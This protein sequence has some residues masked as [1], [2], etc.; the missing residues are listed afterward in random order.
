[1]STFNHLID[2]IL[3]EAGK[4]TKRY[5]DTNLG[6]FNYNGK[7][8]TKFDILE[9]T[10]NF[11][12]EDIYIK[13][14]KLYNEY[15]DNIFYV[16][17]DDD[18]NKLI[19]DNVNEHDIIYIVLFNTS[20]D[21]KFD[22]DDEKEAYGAWKDLNLSS[23]ILLDCYKF[24]TQKTCIYLYYSNIIYQKPNSS[25]ITY[26]ELWLKFT[27]KQCGYKIYANDNNSNMLIIYK[28]LNTI[29]CTDDLYLEDSIQVEKIS[30]T[31]PYILN[32]GFSYYEKYGAI[33]VGKYDNNNTLQDIKK[34][35]TDLKKNYSE[36]CK[37]F[38]SISNSQDEMKQFYDD[39]TRN[40]E[41][42][43]EINKLKTYFNRL[44]VPHSRYSNINN[45][46]ELE[47]FK[48][49]LT[50]DNINKEYITEIQSKLKTQVDISASNVDALTLKGGNITLKQKLELYFLKYNK[51]K[52]KYID[53]KN[54]N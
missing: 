26:A 9:K 45:I 40:R 43:I 32:K 19:S 37:K 4:E 5:E 50:Y 27:S 48:P 44:T 41:F 25:N 2:N 46:C 42:I 13:F 12:G 53:L 17:Y 1:M 8:Y 15:V 10:Y 20:L 24:S 28:F 49:T 39:K 11:D 47:K 22:D 38:I 16:S 31:I 33:P 6:L 34:A 54:Q 52:D 35:Y 29:N 3:K 30:I 36:I 51:Y 7:F 14:I 18:T 21:Y 23:E